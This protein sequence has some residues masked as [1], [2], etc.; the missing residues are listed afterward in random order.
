[1]SK[2]VTQLPSAKQR[3]IDAFLTTLSMT[4]FADMSVKQL[5]LEAQVSRATFYNC[6]SDKWALLDEVR[7][8]LNQTLLDFYRTHD[9]PFSTLAICRHILR[10]RAFYKLEF[11]DAREVQKLSSALVPLLNETFHDLDYATFASY[12]TIGYLSAWARHDFPVSPPEAAHKLMKIGRT[13]WA[14]RVDARIEGME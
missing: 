4:P 9:N 10:Y 11:N 7:E 14:E 12:G 3:I 13:N 6:F 2:G 1:M 8:Q 5:V